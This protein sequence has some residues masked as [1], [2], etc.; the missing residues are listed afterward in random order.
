MKYLLITGS[1]RSGTTY[2]FKAFQANKNCEMIYQPTLRIFKYLDLQIRKKLNKKIFNNFPLGLTNISKKI[3]FNKIHLSKNEITKILRNLIK[4]KDQNEIYYKN[5]YEK[6]FSEKKKINYQILIN[7]MFSSI[8]KNNKKKIYGIKELY[9]ADISKLLLNLKDLYIINIVRDPREILFSRNYS[10]IK[11]HINF[12][13]KKH[14]VILN[15][16]LCNQNMKTDQKLKKNK[17]YLSIKFD[18]LI[19]NKEKVEKKIK[20]FL[21]IKI[22]LN[23][24]NIQKKTKW[25]INSSGNKPNYGSKWLKYLKI[26]ELTIVEKIC[27]QN[28]EKY[29]YQIILKNKK[30]IQNNLKLFKEDKSKI[31]NWT[32]K[33]MFLKYRKKQYVKF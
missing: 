18:D 7:H 23:L 30:E 3:N 8:Q 12:K 15:A 16:L 14:P 27:G 25:K 13:D 11:N 6:I 24:T 33:D 1:Y 31:L 19:K 20:R 9:I 21:K 28:M 4:L 32:K 10:K 5:F 2:L 17:N 26:N 22:S 29:G